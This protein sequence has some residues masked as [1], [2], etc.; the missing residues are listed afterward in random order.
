M[1]TM[2]KTALEDSWEIIREL[3]RSQMRKIT[4]Q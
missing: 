4:D 1:S 3:G 2:K